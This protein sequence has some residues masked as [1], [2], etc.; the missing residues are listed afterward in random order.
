[1]CEYTH[2]HIGCCFWHTVGENS[3]YPF[4]HTFMKYLKNE[5]T[6]PT[7]TWFACKR[8]N[9]VLVLSVF[10]FRWGLHFCYSGFCLFYRS[11]SE[12]LSRRN[13]FWIYFQCAVIFFSFSIK[14]FTNWQLTFS[15]VCQ[16]MCVCVVLM[17]EQN[18]TF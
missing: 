16:K 17:K 6:F 1:M 8:L 13:Q 14:F 18:L 9:K 11:K 5:L 15:T 10:L 4:A 12:S 7:D 3:K 2:T